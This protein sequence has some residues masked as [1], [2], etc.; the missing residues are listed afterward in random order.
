MVGFI[1]AVIWRIKTSPVLSDVVSASIKKLSFYPIVLIICWVPSII[2]DV[3]LRE[4]NSPNV[5]TTALE[6][7]GNAFPILQGFFAA[8]VFFSQNNLVRDRWMQVYR[9]RLTSLSAK[10]DLSVN[11]I[12]AQMESDYVSNDSLFSGHDGRN[13]TSSMNESFRINNA[14]T[15]DRIA[16]PKLSDISDGSAQSNGSRS[17]NNSNISGGHGSGSLPDKFTA[18]KLSHM[19][20][21]Q[22]FLSP[23]LSQRAPTTSFLYN[24]PL[25]GP[26]VGM[27]VGGGD[28]PGGGVFY[29][30]A[31]SSPSTT[32][33]LS[34][35]PPL[36]MGGGS[37]SPPS[38][39]GA[40]EMRPPS[41]AT[42][43]HVT[44]EVAEVA[45]NSEAHTG[46]NHSRAEI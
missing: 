33:S 43:S 42:A 13:S 38:V 18:P 35:S 5:D 20:Y 21:P 36:V 3:V 31:S 30:G 24:N 4:P 32:P 45:E 29:A 1:L 14:P 16:S 15:S 34:P 19:S 46:T 2:A 8:C 37:G 6:I 11:F 41:T 44:M 28:Y 23:S 12:S 25:P 7:C 17:S 26:N 9:T 10:D 39:N 22:G 40:V 27:R